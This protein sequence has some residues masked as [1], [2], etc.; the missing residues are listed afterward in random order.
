MKS[1]NYLTAFVIIFSVFFTNILLAQKGNDLTNP[2]DDIDNILRMTITGNG[3][4]DQ[5][6]VVFIPDATTGF[7]S[8][9]DAYKLMGIM[10]APQLY[11]KIS[12]CNLSVNALPKIHTNGMVQL[13]F[14]VGATTSYTISVDKLYTFGAD[15]NI[16]LEDTKENVLQELTVDSIYTFTGEPSDDE[17]RFLLHFNYP[18]KLDLKAWLEGPFNGT[19]MNTDLNSAGELP[20][21]QPYSGY[22]WFYT[23]TESVASIPNS[24][25]VDWV[26][27]ELRDATD[28]A[29]ATDATM[30][31]QHACFI[32]NDGSIVGMD[33]SSYPEFTETVDEEIFVVVYHRNHLPIL[34]GTA[35]SRISG[36][37]PFDYTTA[38]SQAYGTTA[39]TDLGGVYGL[40][41]GDSDADG[42][43]NNNDKIT[44]WETIV[45]SHGY[46]GSDYNCDGEVDNN[47]KNDFWLNNS[48]QNSQLP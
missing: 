32:L 9:Y 21:S 31:E 44:F 45:G 40:Y 48:G 36:L 27:V 20:L 13:G 34:S 1:L 46:L 17:T 30:L 29:S 6:F 33:G 39:Q 38:A 26:L 5:T 19:D 43:I 2:T 12:C 41:A 7:D 37:Y 25:I 16:I 47:D 24:N 10:A 3:Y 18:V 11:S 23:G 15:T 14:R 8:D 22:P 35:V 4:S 42:S 28:A